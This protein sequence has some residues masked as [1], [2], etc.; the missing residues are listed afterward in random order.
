MMK[1]NLLLTALVCILIGWAGSTAT[2]LTKTDGVY[3]I[4]TA[5]DLID[6]SALVNAGETDANAVMTADIKMSD[7]EFTPIGNVSNPY[8]G[9]FDGQQHFVR[10]LYI[11]LPEQEYLG[12]F[13]V[14]SNGAIIKN[15]V[16]DD[17]CE[18]NGKAFVGLAG[19][20]NG[21]GTVTFENCGN[22]G[23]IGAQNQNAAGIC[24]VSMGS[25]CGIKMI[26][27]FNS[28]MVIGAIESAA[29]CGWVG[30]N[31]SE[32]TNCYNVGTVMGMDG[33]NSL[34]RNGAGKGT[35]NYDSY[36]NQGTL[37]QETDKSTGA[38]AY[39]MNGNQ[40]EDV[41]WY[42]TLGTDE[43]PV[44][45]SSHG[46][47]YAVGELYCDG[48]S[49]G[50]E[51]SF[52]NE[53]NSKRDPHQFQNGI[54]TVCGD[55]DTEYLPLTDG[56]YTLTTAADLNW[57]AA[58]VNH[59]KKKVNARLGADINFS[60]YTAQ[61]VMIGGDAYTLDEAHAFEGVFDGQE[62]TITI[63]YKASYK[64]VGLFKVINNA[65]IR[66]LRVEGSIEST[67]QYAGGLA[68]MTRGTVL[69]ENVVV[70]VNMTLSYVGDGTHG[71]V[72]AI[73]HES[74]TYRNCAFVGTM[75]GPTCEG[76]AGII[77]YA[78]GRVETLIENCFV[79]SSLM[80][81]AG[82]ST[83][84]A[85]N[86]NTMKNIYY[87]D[88]IIEV[89]D[90]N[91]EIVSAEVVASGELAWKLNG[92]ENAGAWRQNLG[93]DPYPLPFAS[94]AAVYANGKLSCDGKPLTTSFSNTDEGLVREE[95]AYVDHIC[96]VCGARII[97]T[98]DELRALAAGI[99]DGTINPEIIVDMTSD[100]DLGNVPFAGIGIRE[101]DPEVYYPFKGV[102]DGHGHIVNNMLIES[103][104]GNKGLFG[105]ISGATIKNVVVR[106]EI[107]S[108]GYSAG[109]VGTA[110]GRAVVT[111]ENCGNEATVNVGVE[112]ANGAGI[113]GVND[114]SE[115]E[116][117]I[118]NCYNT[119]DIVGQRECAAISGWLGD[120]GEVKNCYNSGTVNPEAIDGD[121]TFA[122]YNG[123]L[124]T[125]T[126]CY[127]VESRQVN[128]VSSESVTDGSLCEFLNT[129][130]GYEVYKQG[131]KH[132]VLNFA[133]EATGVEKIPTRAAK[134]GE[135]IFDLQGRRQA[136]M[137]RGINI[138]RMA[139][140][141]VK[142]VLRD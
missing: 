35:N 54:C 75:D 1:K 56:Y 87:S 85:R 60:E 57:F 62:H 68:Y 116:V 95:H 114:L 93:G 33:S 83:V 80:S 21:G 76:S 86:V 37:I 12:L 28:G 142:K 27:C 66:N 122:R 32:I 30:N 58:L 9:I 42:Q 100:I 25:S 74:P 141:T 48:T 82:N 97:T 132:P 136:T 107:Y 98:A 24:G 43:Y 49:K 39:Q 108:T 130:A 101:G 89:S 29:L 104:Y 120:R 92:K 110:R 126:N 53:N 16:L 94:H 137:Q 45:F 118:I 105:V 106:G 18:F 23:V 140:G 13:G 102:F 26:N 40:S 91:A 64:G 112:G 133:G 47:V 134:A 5:Q 15:V 31:G 77:G 121:R 72:C 8:H 7:M 81:L 127:E 90:A 139:D 117:H 115:S 123:S 50:G 69:I 119:G 20:T 61:D 17:K 99:N 135:M 36:G 14:I 129:G 73:S 51:T 3:Q 63:N 46:V 11:N 109:I 71:G 103:S 59:G 128:S 38:M 79:A 96:S 78:H 125:F 84:F 55:V 19:G 138:I 124:I 34:W 44:P 4:G 6:F 67:E 131:D 88:N 70:G 22:A 111:I 41:V 113:L 2:A 10:D 52:S 65:T